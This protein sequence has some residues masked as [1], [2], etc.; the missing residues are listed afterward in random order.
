VSGAP[1]SQVALTV[2]A[3]SGQPYFRGTLTE[4]K[5][6]QFDVP[7]GPLQIRY[8]IETAEGRLIDSDTRELN[9]PD[10]SRAQ[11]QL[12]TPTVL[13]GRTVRELQTLRTDPAAA[14][15]ASREFN[16][17]ERLI[18]RV[19]AY[20]PGGQSLTVTAKL[21]NR[22]GKVMSDLPVKAPDAQAGAGDYETELPLSALAAGEYLVEFKAAAPGGGEARELVPFRITS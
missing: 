21:L 22:T 19:R 6:A 10:Y 7:P 14:P 3:P 8:N 18:V 4:H 16:R 1:P 11:V 13:R 12:S 2:L 20:A 5:A 9:A 15:S 17:A